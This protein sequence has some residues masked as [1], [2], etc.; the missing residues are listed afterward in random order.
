MVSAGLSHGQLT[1][2]VPKAGEPV[3]KCCMLVVRM[4]DMEHSTC[5]SQI[6]CK[7]PIGAGDPI[8]HNPTHMLPWMNMMEQENNITRS[9]TSVHATTNSGGIVNLAICGTHTLRFIAQQSIITNCPPRTTLQLTNSDS[10]YAAD[11]QLDSEEDSGSSDSSDSGDDKKSKAKK[12]AKKRK[13]DGI[14]DNDKKPKA[15]KTNKK[16][17]PD[18]AS[19]DDKKPKAKKTNK[20]RKAKNSS[21]NSDPD[22]DQEKKE[23][24]KPKCSWSPAKSPCKKSKTNMEESDK[25]EGDSDSVAS[26]DRKPKAKDCRSKSPAQCKSAKLKKTEEET[27]SDPGSS[28]IGASKSKGEHEPKKTKLLTTLEC[29]L[30][31]RDSEKKKILKKQ[32]LS[33]VEESSKELRRC[34]PSSTEC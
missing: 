18:D 22:L 23:R 13:H 29:N 7:A 26:A 31:R 25:D 12:N 33:A 17:K 10:S 3:P 24:A 28:Y 34:H 9:M 16:R 5:Q 30:Q 14:S 8:V 15:K 19:N 4:K 6:T 1:R 2:P 27:E 32:R 11:V 20:K 21:D